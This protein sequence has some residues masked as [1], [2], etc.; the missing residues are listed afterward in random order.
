MSFFLGEGATVLFQ[1]AVCV[2]TQATNIIFCVVIY[3]A[4]GTWMRERL[5]VRLFLFQ[6]RL[7]MGPHFAASP[8]RTSLS[9]CYKIATGNP[10]AITSLSPS[11]SVWVYV[12]V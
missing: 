11:L 10:E 12:C 6:E 8:P 3:D 2:L 1:P 5:T 4:L 9:P 7:I